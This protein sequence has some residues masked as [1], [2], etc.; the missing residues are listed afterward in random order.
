MNQDGGYVFKRA[1]TTEEFEQIHRLNYRTFVA[2][3]PQHHDTGDGRLIDKFHAKNTYFIAIRQDQVVGMISVHDQPPFSV[4]ERLPDPSIL[5]R[6]GSRPIEV[7]LLAVA[8]E[9][10]K[11]LVLMGLVCQFYEYACA[12]GYT[13]A[14]IS[15]IEDRIP[16]YQ[17][18]GFEPLGPAVRC[19]EACFVPMGITISQLVRVNEQRAGMWRKR[20]GR[21]KAPRREP[22]CLLPGPV[23]I[24]PAVHA[25]FHQPPI[26]H[27]GQEFT[28]LYES[29]RCSLSHIVNG[30]NVAILNGSGT[31]AN[32][33]VAATLAAGPQPGDGVMLVNGEFGSRLAR[34]AARFGL[35]PRVLTWAWGQPWDLDQVENVLAQEPAGSWIWGVHQESS[36]G[37]LND[38][39]GLVDLAKRHKIRVCVDC[40]SS[41]G[42]VPLDLSCVHLATAA[43]GKSLGAFA[44][45]AIVFADARQ[46]AGL[47]TS[48]VPS[49]LDLPA[50]LACTGTR[51]TFPSP[52]L[53]ALDAALANYATPEKARTCYERYAMLGIYVREQLRRLG[54]EPL[55]KDSCAA[56]VVTTFAP[57]ERESSEAFVARCHFWGYELGGQSG[58]LAERR[59]VQI[60]T[61]GAVTREL[62]A[63][64]F[65]RLENSLVSKPELATV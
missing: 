17:Q 65:T 42:A 63:P 2:E 58:Y 46:L 1:E 41:L 35:T 26:Y 32:E 57:P 33:V 38:L 43:S 3:I 27:R 15:G 34:Q 24:S 21:G 12:Q 48:R 20:M 55:A 49:Y 50:A 47:D 28:E 29:V 5:T 16:L 10:R 22:V 7:R 4:A 19:G 52:T 44:G 64:L 56:P 45:A 37:V 30:R 62:C 40:I 8:P 13:H 14:Y 54:L 39:P 6:P 25:A 36:T 61:M 59:L 51:Y 60:A 9:Q 31:A 23:S 11:T 53:L 18:F